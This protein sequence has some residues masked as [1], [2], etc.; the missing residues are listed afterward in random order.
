MSYDHFVL[1]NSQGSS[2]LK[3][4]E[5]GRVFVGASLRRRPHSRRTPAATTAAAAAANNDSASNRVAAA[6][7]AGAVGRLRARQGRNDPAGAESNHARKQNSRE[8]EENSD[9]AKSQAASQGAR[10]YGSLK[11]CGFVGFGERGRELR[12]D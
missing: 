8:E 11:E 2:R 4:M 3:Q 12:S 1:R 6:D 7:E 10:G 5:S 9:P